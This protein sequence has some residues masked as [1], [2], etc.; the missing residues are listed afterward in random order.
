MSTVI[1]HNTFISRRWRHHSLMLL[2]TKRFRLVIITLQF[3]RHV[4]FS[5][6]IYSLL[7]L[8]TNSIIHWIN[9]RTVWEPYV[10]LD[11]VDNL[12]FQ[13]VNCIKSRCIDISSRVYVWLGRV[14]AEWRW[15]GGRY[16]TFMHHTFLVIVKKWLKLVHIYGSYRKI[17]TG[18]TFLDQSVYQLLCSRVAVSFDVLHQ[19]S[20]NFFRVEGRLS[21]L[22]NLLR[23]TCR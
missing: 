4:K 17:K 5:S 6:M 13:I 16:F 11:E 7:K 14:V 3:F 21:P 20:A 9:I 18:I 10:K 22:V 15:S 23:A 1:L 12:F 2:S 8:I 19:G